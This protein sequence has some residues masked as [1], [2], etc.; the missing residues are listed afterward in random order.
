MKFK[1]REPQ[2]AKLF[3]AGKSDEFPNLEVT[4]SEPIR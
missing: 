1:G 2:I 3:Y 4:A